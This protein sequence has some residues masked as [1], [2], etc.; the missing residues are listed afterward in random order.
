LNISRDNSD[1]LNEI[2]TDLNKFMHENNREKLALL[3]LESNKVSHE[4]EGSK[5]DE[6]EL[7][8]E[9]ISNLKDAK[10]N[11]IIF[12]HNH[13]SKTTFSRND[14]YQI[15]KY[16]SINSMTLECID[17]SKFVLKRGK[18]KSSFLNSLKFPS[19]Y[20]EIY[21]RVA[22]RYPGLDDEVE[23]Y[24]IW[25]EFLGEVTKEVSKFYGLIYKGVS[26]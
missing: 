12:S 22:K 13:P 26:E 5:D 18:M 4:L 3:D 6:I 10:E 9:I 21:W 14:I 25:D 23:I 15:I 7:T 11:N 8:K 19:K 1:K 17:G 16:K 2:H 24:K 20:D